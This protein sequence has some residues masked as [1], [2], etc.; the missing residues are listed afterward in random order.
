ML[1]QTILTAITLAVLGAG[2]L[3]QDDPIAEPQIDDIDQRIEE[4]ERLVP[5]PP[6]TT[7]AF[8]PRQPRT[9]APARPG[10]TG[11]RDWAA[12]LEPAWPGVLDA[13]LLAERTFL[14]SIRGTVRRGPRETRIFIPDRASDAVSSQRAMLLLPCAVLERFNT[15]TLADDPSAP[16]MLSGQVFLYGNR[17]YVLPTS[18]RWAADDPAEDRSTAEQSDDQGPL[19]RATGG[20]NSPD[21]AGGPADPFS[22]NPDT[23]ALMAELER[24]S[25]IARPP[26]RPRSPVPDSDR[27]DA[28]VP[29]ADGAYVAAV[30]GR[31][32][33]TPEGFWSFVVDA[34]DPAAGRDSAYT[35]LP[36][37]TLEALEYQALYHGDSV[38]GLISG[39]VY[40]FGGHG[41]LLPTLYQTE[42]RE[43]VDPLQ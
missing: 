30:R 38:A 23:T 22:D 3:G 8:S 6:G 37:R 26:S 40:R 5:R 29:V 41:F 9:S 17:N 19:D 25:P 18:V 20:G 11:G 43:G 14:N 42:R 31:I 28:S 2:V 10:L 33:R 13:P 32:V 1:R 15:F 12:M 4:A 16:V 39:R 7:E 21:G 24:R 35:L 34:D 36:C 27:D